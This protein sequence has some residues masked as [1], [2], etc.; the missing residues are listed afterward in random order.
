MRVTKTITF[1]HT[2]RHLALGCR[3]TDSLLYDHENKE[4]VSDEKKD[5]YKIVIDETPV[6]KLV[7]YLYNFKVRNF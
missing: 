1:A 6:V 7:K 4:F 3:I 2:N 5:Q